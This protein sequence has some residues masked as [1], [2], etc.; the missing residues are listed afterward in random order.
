MNLAFGESRTVPAS[1]QAKVL[2]KQ[3]VSKG[4][5]DEQRDVWT[6][7]ASLGIARGE[8]YISGN[9]GTFQN[10]NSLDPEA[11]FAAIMI[12]LYPNLAPE[13]RL[14]KLVDHAEWG[15]REISKKIDNGT[16]DWSTLG[17]R[18]AK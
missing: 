4:I 14:R 9:R 11:V 12:G 15:I 17:I 10:I 5:F 2:M 8:I 3:L 13:D 1:D 6:L 18:G 16:L 7:G